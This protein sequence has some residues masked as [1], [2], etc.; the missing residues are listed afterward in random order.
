M[1]ECLHKEQT[2]RRDVHD[3]VVPSSDLPVLMRTKKN[4]K[5]KKTHKRSLPPSSHSFPSLCLFVRRLIINL[6]HTA[7]LSRNS[8]HTRKREIT[9]FCFSVGLL[10]CQ[11]AE[12][13]L[14]RSNSLT[15]GLTHSPFQVSFSFL[16]FV[17][18]KGKKKSGLC[19]ETLLGCDRVDNSL[20]P[21]QGPRTSL[22]II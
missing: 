17:I 14:N 15:I 19:A 9:L 22:S 6:P 5:I 10:A 11:P 20:D 7:C 2:N 3:T 12:E 18:A 21:G 1:D 4:K 8:L 13:E 16:S